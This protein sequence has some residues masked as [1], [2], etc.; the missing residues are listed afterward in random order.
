MNN[1]ITCEVY[2]SRRLFTWSWRFRFIA[3][4]GQKLGHNYNDL[5]DALRAVKLIADPRVPMRLVVINRDGVGTDRG[6]IRP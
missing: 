6:L 2:E 4:N 1:G 3:A 5:A